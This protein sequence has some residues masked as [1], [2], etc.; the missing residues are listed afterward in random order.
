MRRCVTRRS[1]PSSRARHRIHID[2]TP[3]AFGLSHT[4]WRNK[5]GCTHS[6]PPRWAVNWAVMAMAAMEQPSAGHLIVQSVMVG[7]WRARHYARTRADEAC[8]SWQ[9]T[10][11][12][13][14]GEVWEW[15]PLGAHPTPFT[16]SIAELHGA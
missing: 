15:S 8:P 3:S 6:G 12:N 10:R 16:L 13:Q 7:G 9:C 5:H 1:P 4:V 14:L 2:V 11:S